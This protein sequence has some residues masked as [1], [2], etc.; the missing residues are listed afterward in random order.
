MLKNT[1]IKTKNTKNKVR[2]ESHISPLHYN[3]TLHPDLLSFIFSGKE[4][5]KIKI[6]KDVKQITLHSKDIKIQTAEIIPKKINQ[7]ANKISYDEKK[8]TTTFYF[9]NTINKGEY[10]LSIIFSGVINESLRGFYKSKYVLDGEEKYIATTQFEATDARRAFPCFDEPAHKAVFEVSL[11]IPENHTAIS[12]T[13]PTSIKEHGAGFNIVTFAPTPVMSTYLL[14]FIIGEFE[15]IEG[16]SK[17]GVQ[18]RIFT[19]KNKTHQA[20]FALD[21]AIKS[22][23]FF[24]DYFDIPYPMPNLDLI[25]IPDFEPAGMEN[26]GSITFRESSILIDENFS[27]I[28]NKQWVAV[29]IAHEIAHQWFGNLVTMHWWTD[30]WLNEGFASYM[31][32]VCTH[33]LFPHWKIWDLYLSNGRYR[34]AI[35]ID[36]LKNSHAIE[37]ELNHPNE[38]NETFDMVSYEKGT[39]VIRM[40][41]E[42]IG[43]DKFKEGLRYY[44]KK[45]SYKNT[46]TVDLWNAF[47]KV[48]KR[49]IIEIMSSWT[50]QAGFPVLTLQ[51]INKEKFVL[52][53]EKFFS[54]R[55]TRQNNKTKNNWEITVIYKSNNTIKKLL[56]DKKSI[57]IKDTSLQKINVDESSFIK[58]IYDNETLKIIKKEIEENHISKIDRLGLIRDIFALAEGGY[59]RT[60][61]A[62]KFSL[63]FKNETEYIVLEEITYGINRIYNLIGKE[64]FANKYNNYAL[65]L[66]S[67]L[68]QKI[69]FERKNNEESSHTLLRILVISSASFYGDKKIIEEAEKLFSNRIIKPIDPDMRDVIYNTVARNGKIK[70]WN[71]FKEMYKAETLQEEKE[72]LSRAM[73]KFKDVKLLEK[74]LHFI[75]SKEIRDQDAP[76][77]IANIWNNKFGQDL[78]WQFLKDNWELILKR[79]GEAGLLLSKLIFI[80]GNHTS[81]KDLKDA[82]KFFSRNVAPGAE[83]TLEQAYERMESNIA[84]LKD[85]KKSIKDWLNK[86]Y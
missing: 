75:I 69:G 31:E 16:K 24:E 25:A 42:Y 54:S 35:E 14:A 70:E 62:L 38:I 79:Y 80:L 32:K 58:V 55:V 23:D 4:I 63:S 68:A 26:W 8:E 21:V 11:I 77:L 22:L 1:K 12:N 7:F 57:Q 61:E 65:S 82:K 50:K 81:V 71:I 49:P 72:S 13:L 6:D 66:F 19:T 86:N 73:T 17:D 53:Q 44:L 78:T 64:D 41:S 48:S 56:L 83:K 36:S 9:K 47:E 74:T 84:W 29:V 33:A 10:N 67:P 2:L 30:L 3:I 5:I 46:N 37:V 20:K 27:S 60:D 15:Y 18:I 59:I 76:S 40:L 85:D 52:K 28:T 39:A 34:L 51:K 43:E 45:H